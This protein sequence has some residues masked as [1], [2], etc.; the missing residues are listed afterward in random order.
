MSEDEAFRRARASKIARQFPVLFEQVAAGEIHLTGI[1]LL[2]PHLTEENHLEVLARAKHRTKKEIK[3]LVRMLDPLPDVPALVEPLGP[4]PRSIAG[5]PT[6]SQMV[7]AHSPE[8]RELSPGD[9][10]KDWVADAVAGAELDADAETRRR[11]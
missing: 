8:I 5:N 2:G 11:R 9:R 3:R 4:A 10:P 6:W 7:E 1:L